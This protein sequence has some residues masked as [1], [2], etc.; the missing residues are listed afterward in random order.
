MLKYHTEIVHNRLLLTVEF[1][2]NRDQRNQIREN[3]AKTVFPDWQFL[4]YLDCKNRGSMTF[5]VKR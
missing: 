4:S 1:D 5:F 2:G 3:L